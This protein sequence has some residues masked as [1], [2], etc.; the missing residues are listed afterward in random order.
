MR[1]RELL[2]KSGGAE[3]VSLTAGTAAVREADATHCVDDL[4]ATVEV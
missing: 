1:R 3:A 2:R 4:A